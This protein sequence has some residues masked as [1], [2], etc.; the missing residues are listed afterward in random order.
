MGT[1]PPKKK[2]KT[3]CIIG[4]CAVLL[5]IG[6][7][8]TIVVVRS[9]MTNLPTT[10]TTPAANGSNVLLEDNF[11]STSSGFEEWDQ[12]D[13]VGAYEDGTYTIE[14]LVPNMFYWSNTGDSYSDFVVDVDTVK[15]GGS[16]DNHFGLVLRYQDSD[17]FYMFNVSSDGMYSFGYYEDD[18]WT[19][20]VK[21]TDSS[22]INQGDNSRNHL[23]VEAV[24]DTFTLMVN[25]EV[26]E[27]VHDT[28][29]SSGDIGMYAGSIDDPGT[30]IAFDNLAIYEVN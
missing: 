19:A 29:F 8:L 13:S 28:T 3:G 18:E 1:T 23:T 5:I 7:I 6:I 16:D 26:L 21:W 17:N 27:I 22:V 9:V 11:S 2:S 15:R 10:I 12:F 4:G 25:G 24:G 20:I 30:K 14:V